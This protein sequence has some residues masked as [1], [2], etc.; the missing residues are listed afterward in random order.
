MTLVKIV[1]GRTATL[2][3]LDRGR[4]ARCGIRYGFDLTLRGPSGLFIAVGFRSRREF[5]TDVAPL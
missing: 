4:F 2:T 1:A 5:V 3:R